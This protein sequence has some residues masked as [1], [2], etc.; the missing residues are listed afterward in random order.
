MIWLNIVLLLWIKNEKD[1]FWSV[2]IELEIEDP[3]N[4]WIKYWNKM[5]RK[6]FAPSFNIK[7]SVTQETFHSGHWTQ[8]VWI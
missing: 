1:R 5:L 6:R 2:Q 3:G 7:H 4:Q 8:L